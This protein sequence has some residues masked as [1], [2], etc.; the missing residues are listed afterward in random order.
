MWPNGVM[1][2]S[3][4]TAAIEIKANRGIQPSC[5]VVAGLLGEEIAQSLGLKATTERG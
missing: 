4:G 1:C 5:S 3:I 2:S